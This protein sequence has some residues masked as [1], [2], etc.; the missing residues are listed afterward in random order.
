MS[1]KSS[2]SHSVERENSPRR[3][4]K[5]ETRD[6]PDSHKIFLTNLNGDYNEEE[7]QN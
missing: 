6:D 2:K 7:V 1:S 4:E 3:E 5:K